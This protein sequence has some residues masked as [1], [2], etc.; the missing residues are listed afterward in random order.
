[1]NAF[2]IVSISSVKE[3]RKY[4]NKSLLCKHTLWGGSYH[5]L[6]VEILCSLSLRF[7]NDTQQKVKN[8]E[9]MVRCY[10]TH[11]DIFSVFE[12]SIAR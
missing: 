4:P 3:V 2:K 11:S 7:S 8:L 10:F 6:K 12:T 9:G 5:T 1:M